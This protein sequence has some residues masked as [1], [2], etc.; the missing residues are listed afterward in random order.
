MQ[1][2]FAGELIFLLLPKIL[3]ER[4]VSDSFATEF[5]MMYTE[6]ESLEKKDEVWQSG[7]WQRRR[8]ILIE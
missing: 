8:L 2:I 4:V 5:G 7:F 3:T 1:A 6:K